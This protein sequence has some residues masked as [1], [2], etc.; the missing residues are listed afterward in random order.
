MP[1]EQPNNRSKL[2]A[3]VLV[4]LAILLFVGL[5]AAFNAHTI[6]QDG[7][8]PSYPAGSLVVAHEYAYS[9]A[10]DVQRGD[11][12]IFKAEHEGETYDFIWRVVGLPGEE[13]AVKDGELSIDGKMIEREVLGS[14]NDC[15]IYREQHASASFEIAMCEIFADSDEFEATLGDGEFFVMGD[16]RLQAMD[17][18]ELGPID[19]EQIQAK[20]VAGPLR[21]E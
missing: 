8:F 1:Q 18:R 17:S 4:V 14:R 12:V 11:V 10:D 20:V 9:D 5:R 15:D 3:I 21:R 19:F 2:I 16:N 7:M 13:V 6:P